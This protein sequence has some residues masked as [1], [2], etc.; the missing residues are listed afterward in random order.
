MTSTDARLLNILEAHG[1]TFLDSFKP[2]KAEENKRKRA[3]ADTA[4]AHPSKL[5]KFETDRSSSDD[6]SDSVEEWTGFGSDAQIE[7]E[8]EID[9]STEEGMPLE[10]VLAR[11]QADSACNDS[12]LILMGCILIATSTSVHKPDVV[13]FSDFGRKT[14]ES[15]LSKKTQGKSFMVRSL[16][17]SRLLSPQPPSKSSKV[18][19]LRD[20]TQEQGTNG[21]SDPADDEDDE[22]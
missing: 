2:H 18:S 17:L 9:S 7:D 22:L 16:Q 5:V 20:E 6:Y 14:S 21:T 4:E 10:G 15:S 13:V 11:F 12:S 3:A 8:Y 19:K 1:Q